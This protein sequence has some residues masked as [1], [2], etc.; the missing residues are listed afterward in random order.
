M[1]QTTPG[2]LE[3]TL[4]SEHAAAI[5][6]NLFPAARGIVR[7]QIHFPWH[8][9]E[10]NRPTAA[11][12]NSSQALAIDV[13]WTIRSLPSRDRIIDSWCDHLGLPHRGPWEIQLEHVVDRGLLGESRCTQL[14]AIA[15]SPDGL[16]IIECKFTESDGG[17]CSQWKPITG[18]SPNAG[19]VQCNGNYEP[20]VNPVNGKTAKCALTAKGIRYWEVVP[21]VL[22]IA[23][24]SFY[25]PCPFKGGWYQWMRNLVTASAM[26]EAAGLP[27]AF[28][29]A[30]AD[31]PFPMAQ[32]IAEADTESQSDWARL[33]GMTAGRSVPLRTC[34]YQQLLDIA[35]DVAD[36]EDSKTILDLESWLS[37][38][39][40][41]ASLL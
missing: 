10:L 12:I 9:D 18:R 16:L 35:K 3:P 26:G 34:S 14:D 22:R 40:C 37:A 15:T 36:V 8:R 30:Y 13:L 17:S 2:E 6:N 25:Q 33:T 20:Q 31:G 21:S 29:V 28:V 23:A 7:D 19:S 27:A 32:K 39:V 38:K 24:D 41:R 5:E 11:L 4:S 1:T